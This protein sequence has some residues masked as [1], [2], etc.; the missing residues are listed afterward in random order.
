MLDERIKGIEDL[1]QKIRKKRKESAVSTEEKV[2][3]TKMIKIV[4]LQWEV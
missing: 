4:R 3:A 1:Y 2:Y